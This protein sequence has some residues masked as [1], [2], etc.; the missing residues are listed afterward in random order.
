MTVNLSYDSLPVITLYALPAFS[1]CVNLPAAIWHL[2]VLMLDASL[3]HDSSQ[4]AFL[5]TALLPL[6]L[7]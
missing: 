1:S 3:P 4:P 7:E 6:E 2:P 5:L